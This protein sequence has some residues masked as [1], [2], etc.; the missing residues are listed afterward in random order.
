MNKLS[1]LVQLLE[2]KKGLWWGG[3]V[4]QKVSDIIFSVNQL[5]TKIYTIL[6]TMKSN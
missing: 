3:G 4:K 2:S 5:L 1:T 6:L